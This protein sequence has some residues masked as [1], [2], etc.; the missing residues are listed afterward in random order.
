MF[1]SLLWSNN[2]CDFF[3][4]SLYL[5]NN[6][7]LDTRPDHLKPNRIYVYLE[8]FGKCGSISESLWWWFWTF[9]LGMAPMWKHFLRLGHL[10]LFKHSNYL[11]VDAQICENQTKWRQTPS[12]EQFEACQETILV[13]WT[14]GPTFEKYFFIRFPI[15]FKEMR[16]IDN[17]GKNINETNVSFDF[18][19]RE[20]FCCIFRVT[21]VKVFVQAQ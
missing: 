7:L 13:D 5:Q 1:S 20:I 9:S 17:Q 10:Y 3:L 21:K 16:K 6:C 15:Q 2:I 18:S 12:D 19:H 14:A 8:I 4:F 11:S